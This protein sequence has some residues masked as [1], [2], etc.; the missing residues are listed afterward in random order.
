MGAASSVE[1]AEL[2][3]IIGQRIG[4]A[5]DR[6]GLSGAEVG[7][8]L[9]SSASAVSRWRSGKNQP[10]LEQLSRF[11][12]LT[13]SRPDELLAMDLVRVGALSF[14]EAADRLQAVLEAREVGKRTA[15][16][17]EREL[18]SLISKAATV[19]PDDTGKP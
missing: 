12:A 19:R 16:D 11:C 3:R 14:E 9:G 6:A 2:R 13:V 5:I 10:S 4:M 18:R 7:R 17:A 15:D 8:H 1:A